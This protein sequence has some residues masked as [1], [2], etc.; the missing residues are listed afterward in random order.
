LKAIFESGLTYFVSKELR[1]SAVNT[2]ST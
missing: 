2:R 1:S